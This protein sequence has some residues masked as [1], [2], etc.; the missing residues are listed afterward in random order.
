MEEMEE[1]EEYLKGKVSACQFH[2]SEATTKL[3]ELK[4]SQE[5]LRTKASNCNEDTKQRL[6]SILNVHFNILKETVQKYETEYT[7]AFELLKY[8]KDY[9]TKFSETTGFGSSTSPSKYFLFLFT[10][11]K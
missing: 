11:L 4:N 6:D 2:S 10:D 7:A 5:E 8:W 1:M 9:S 3:N